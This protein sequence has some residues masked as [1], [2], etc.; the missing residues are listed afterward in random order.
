[1]FGHNICNLLFKFIDQESYL[2][3]ILTIKIRYFIFN[4]ISIKR[5]YELKNF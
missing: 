5:N 1:L 3:K 4:E 2:T